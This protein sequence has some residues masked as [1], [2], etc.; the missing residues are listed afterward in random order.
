MSMVVENSKVLS[1]MTEKF[2]AVFGDSEGV[3]YFFSPGRINLIGEH[4]DYNGGYVFPASITIG[5]TGLARLRQDNQIKLYSENFP[6]IGVIEFDLAHSS[7]KDG[8][9]WANYVKGMITA[10]K[11]A[12]YQIDKGFELLIKGEIPTASGLSSSASLELL[13][14]VALD[15][16]FKLGV[17]RLELVQLGQKT[18]N[19]F[20]GVNSGILDQFA[21]GFGEVKKAILLDCNTLQ[22]EMVPVEL[23]DYDI[24]IMN[25]NKP[26]ALTESK[27]NERFAETREALKRMQTKLAIQSLGELSNEAFDANTDLIGDDTLIKRARHAVYENNRTKIAKAA[28]VAGNLTKFGELLNASHASLKNDYEV[29]GIELDTLA[30]TAQKQPGVLGARMTGAGFGGCA[31]ALVAHDNVPT[32][33]KV[34]GEVYE[35]KMGY[36]ASFYVAQIGSGATKLSVD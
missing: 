31:I 12:G 32:F 17:P 6:D 29:T 11:A 14:G 35:E 28:F 5:T 10:L 24:V 8:D 25:T 3:E 4:T 27:Y 16:L 23:R 15:D 13:V 9:S 1:G 20:I 33:E 22:Y 30:E 36:P 19:E 18:E 7:V 21:I 34:V 26:R 2:A